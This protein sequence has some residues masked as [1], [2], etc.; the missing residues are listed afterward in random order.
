MGGIIDVKKKGTAIEVYGGGRLFINNVSIKNAK[1]GIHLMPNAAYNDI[2]NVNV[3]CQYITNSSKGI[4][5]EGTNNTFV[6]MRIYHPFI[7]AH[8]TGA[9]NVLINIH[10]LANPNN[11]IASAGFF[12]QSTGNRYSICYSDQYPVGFKMETQT[13]SYFDMCFMYW[14]QA[15]NYQIGFL[16]TGE[17]NSVISDTV[18]SMGVVKEESRG[19]T[20]NHYLFFLDESKEDDAEQTPTVPEQQPTEPGGSQQ[21]GRPSWGGRDEEEES[22]SL[23]SGVASG[24]GVIINPIVQ[25]Q[26]N[27]DSDTYKQFIYNPN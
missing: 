8:L 7:G 6:N 23:K 21:G 12:D 4:F 20:E 3:T 27:S 17:F 5:V 2:E 19:G 15:C 9:D 1:I 22:E 10:P 14:W 24:S 13:K 16:C 26:R 25:Y 11:N 18:V